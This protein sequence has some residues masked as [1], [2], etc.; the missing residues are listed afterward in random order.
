MQYEHLNHIIDEL[1]ILHK[2]NQ[3][4]MNQFCTDITPEQGKLLFLIQYER[5]SQKEIARKLHIS[6]ATLSVRIKRLLD[7]GWI[8]RETHKNDKRINAIVLSCKGKQLMKDLENQFE[9]YR[10]IVCKGISLEDYE[11]VLHV[12]HQIQSNI[13]EEI[14]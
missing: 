5:M 7:S 6:E 9:R 2:L 8:E 10:C 14:K 4:M 13:K 3:S 11:T 12:I 1:K